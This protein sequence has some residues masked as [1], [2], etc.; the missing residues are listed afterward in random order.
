M[1][2]KDGY[3]LERSAVTTSGLIIAL[4]VAAT[5]FPVLLFVIY[6]VF[7]PSHCQY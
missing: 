3:F 4:R 5:V 7:N 6:K 1:S 2:E